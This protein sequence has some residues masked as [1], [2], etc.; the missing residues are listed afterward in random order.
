[1]HPSPKSATTKV[2]HRSRKKRGTLT[3]TSI[4]G[5]YTYRTVRLVEAVVLLKL[6][7]PGVLWLFGRL[8]GHVTENGVPPSGNTRAVGGQSVAGRVP[9]VV[10]SKW[11]E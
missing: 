3:Q 9:G 1:M 2:W 5:E 4:E 11:R 10:R 8:E 6:S 7:N